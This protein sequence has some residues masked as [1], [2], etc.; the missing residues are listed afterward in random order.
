MGNAPLLSRRIPPL[1]PQG[2]AQPGDL[3]GQQGGLHQADRDRRRQR[4]KGAV[5]DGDTGASGQARVEKDGVNIRQLIVHRLGEGMATVWLRA[6]LASV[7]TP[8]S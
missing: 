1:T 5:V 7:S 6:R 8:S 4:R 3:G 2:N